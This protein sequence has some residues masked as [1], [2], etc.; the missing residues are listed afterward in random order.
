MCMFYSER[1]LV[2]CYRIYPN[3]FLITNRILERWESQENNK[4]YWYSIVKIL[5]PTAYILLT[6]K[7]C[8]E[9]STL[10]KAA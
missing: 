7:N 4:R 1:G 6:S 9:F 10:F 2:W 5:E 8:F 3:T